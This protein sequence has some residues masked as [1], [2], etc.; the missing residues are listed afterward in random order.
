MTKLPHRNNRTFYWSDTST[1]GFTL[2]ELLLVLIILGI[3]AAVSVSIYQKLT[4]PD[5]NIQQPAEVNPASP[6]P[7]T[8]PTRKD[9]PWLAA[10]TIETDN[11]G[12]WIEN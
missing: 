12:S 7:A 6:T 3:L 4:T 1:E 11:Q 2:I 8:E 5:A 10:P 9:E